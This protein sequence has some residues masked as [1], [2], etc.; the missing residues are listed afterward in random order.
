MADLVRRVK[1]IN[2]HAIARGEKGPHSANSSIDK[3]LG[4][5]KD[6]DGRLSCVE[7]DRLAYTQREFASGSRQF[8][9]R[10]P[11]KESKIPDAPVWAKNATNSSQKTGGSCIKCVVTLSSDLRRSDL[12]RVEY[13][14]FLVNIQCLDDLRIQ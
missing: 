2:G 13:P 8:D 11:R 1:S 9:E 4:A 6:A 7:R 3:E 10:G 5:L 14:A 12:L